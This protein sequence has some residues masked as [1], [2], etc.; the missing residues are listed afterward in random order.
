MFGDIPKIFD[1]NFI[2]AYLLPC[3][4]V[5][6]FS[7]GI[8]HCLV[9]LN[10]VD[11]A[12]G[13]TFAIVAFALGM[14]LM[15]A[16]RTVTRIFEGYGLFNPIR[17][18]RPI[19]RFRFWYVRRQSLLAKRRR[20]HA[21][22]NRSKLRKLVDARSRSMT[23][24]A[25]RY[26]ERKQLLLSTALG[27]AIRS[28][29]GYPRSMYNFGIIEGWNRLIAVVP[30]EYLDL[31]DSAKAQTDLWINVWL[32]SLLTIFDCLTAWYWPASLR[33]PH[34]PMSVFQLECTC[35]GAAVVVFAAS[36]LATRAAVEW[37]S[38][39]KAMVD[40]FLPTLYAKLGLPP[41]SGNSEAR[42]RLGRFT[43]SIM[44]RLPDVMPDRNW[45]Q[46]GAEKTDSGEPL[47]GPAAGPRTSDVAHEV[48]T[49][50]TNSATL[51][52]KGNSSEIPAESSGKILYFAYG[53][54]MLSSRLRERAPSGIKVAVG[55]VPNHRLTF[56]KRSSS[57][58]GKCDAETTQ[59]AED[60]VWGVIFEI[61]SVQKADLDLLEGLDRGY[62]EKTVEVISGEKRFSAVMYYATD[63]DPSLKP[64][65]WYK[66]LVVAGAREHLLP[67]EYIASIENVESIEDPDA[68][69]AIKQRELL[70]RARQS[71]EPSHS[72]L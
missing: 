63:K 2:I 1:R 56:H 68:A 59:G 12:T 35:I 42:A 4:L 55:W 24:L 32:L 61:D 8:T 29:E 6:A 37:G 51:P 43:R 45:L 10:S 36:S 69:R 53:S 23:R 16:N 52:A 65:S 66:E 38:M 30:K 44:F 48:S 31:V 15:A 19:Q 33:P 64:F 21:Q 22:K 17:V 72:L 62:S 26:P 60:R 11:T 46:A 71:R 20:R 67:H 47:A 49:L 7:L 34:R 13:T 58:S 28:F 39:V 9:A 18:L 54:N 25:E 3:S 57:N 5:L 41:P 14:V 70:S 27:N 40:V 50:A